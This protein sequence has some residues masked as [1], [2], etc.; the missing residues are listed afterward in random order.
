M[1]VTEVQWD[2]GWENKE[3]VGW[4]ESARGMGGEERGGE[5]RRGEGRGGMGEST[6]L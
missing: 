3:G 6:W 1:C 5:G 4:K 2:I